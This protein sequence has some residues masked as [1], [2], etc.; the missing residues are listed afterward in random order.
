MTPRLSERVARRRLSLSKTLH[1]PTAFQKKSCN[2]FRA[3]DWFRRWISFVKRNNLHPNTSQ[4]NSPDDMSS[5]AGLT[6]Q[7]TSLSAASPKLGNNPFQRRRP[8][9]TRQGFFAHLAQPASESQFT[10]TFH[11]AWSVISSA[12]M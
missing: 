5:I 11:S 8:C 4:R 10:V 3:R 1:C 9:R 2:R 6:K 7:L 12:S